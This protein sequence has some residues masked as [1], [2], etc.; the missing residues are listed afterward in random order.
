MNL[1]KRP[2]F[3]SKHLTQTNSKNS[4]LTPP[5]SSPERT[6]ARRSGGIEEDSSTTGS[7]TPM[8][9]LKAYLLLL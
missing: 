2:W 1:I 7:I 9:G 4:L 5:Q 3:G 6:Y 8:N